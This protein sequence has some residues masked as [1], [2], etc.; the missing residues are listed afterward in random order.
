MTL[1]YPYF[2]LF[3]ADDVFDT[4]HL[5]LESIGAYHLLKV[6]YFILGGLPKAD[7]EVRRLARCTNSRRWPAI[8]DELLTHVFAEGWRQQK[9]DALLAEMRAKSAQASEAAKAKNKREYNLEEDV[10]F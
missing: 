4:R 2:K 8:R 9:W 7:D 1:L 10:P 5:Q 6:E 3:I